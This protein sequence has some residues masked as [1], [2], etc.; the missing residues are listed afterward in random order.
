MWYIARKFQIFC[1]FPKNL[2]DDDL[3]SEFDEV[4]FLSLLWFATVFKTRQ[5]VWALL[6]WLQS[7]FAHKESAAV[8]FTLKQFWPIAKAPPIMTFLQVF[9]MDFVNNANLQ[10]P[11]LYYIFNLKVVNSQCMEWHCMKLVMVLKS[12]ALAIKSMIKLDHHPRLLS[13]SV[14]I[15]H[16]STLTLLSCIFSYRYWKGGWNRCPFWKV[17][18]SR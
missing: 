14:S 17:H 5:E 18:D 6:K 1:Y 3:R 10:I 4:I 11:Q 7:R 16:L 9:C 15:N 12:S 2:F 13:C 8:L